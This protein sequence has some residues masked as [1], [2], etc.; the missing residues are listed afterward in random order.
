MVPACRMAGSGSGIC[1]RSAGMRI[2]DNKNTPIMPA[3]HFRACRC[4][5]GTPAFTASAAAAVDRPPC[6]CGYLPTWLRRSHQMGMPDGRE[7][8]CCKDIF[9]A[10]HYGGKKISGNTRASTMVC[11]YIYMCQ[12]LPGQRRDKVAAGHAKTQLDRTPELRSLGVTSP[13]AHALLHVCSM[14]VPHD[15]QGKVPGWC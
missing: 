7:C 4:M 3:A 6:I 10:N 5:W 14:G 2:P 11:V 9:T 13:R 12:L 1:S 8:I 15:A